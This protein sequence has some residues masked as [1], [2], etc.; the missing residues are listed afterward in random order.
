MLAIFAVSFTLQLFVLL[1][2]AHRPKR[3]HLSTVSFLKSDLFAFVA[4]HSNACASFVTYLQ[5]MLASFRF[6]SQQQRD[7]IMEPF[8]HPVKSDD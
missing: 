3:P 6:D 2:F 5:H 8:L 7:G 1:N 4:S